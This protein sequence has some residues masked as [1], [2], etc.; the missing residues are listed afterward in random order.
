AGAED[1]MMMRLVELYFIR[2]EATAQLGDP[3][4]AMQDVNLIRTRA[5]LPPASASSLA[6]ALG[7]ILHERQVELFME[8]AHRW[9]DLKRMDSVNSV[10]SRVKPQYWPADG[11]AALYPISV[12]EMA[13]NINLVQNPGY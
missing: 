8:G 1:L 2:A 10:M 3:A 6:E 13:A 12:T 9:F 5:A 4:S 11:H 7:I